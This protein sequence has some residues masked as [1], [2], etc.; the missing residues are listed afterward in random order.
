MRCAAVT[1]FASE[2][3][4]FEHM[5]RDV[6]GS[7]RQQL[8]AVSKQARVAHSLVKN[9]TQ[10]SCVCVQRDECKGKIPQV[11]TQLGELDLALAQLQELAAAVSEAL[12]I[13]T[14]VKELE[15][16]VSKVARVRADAV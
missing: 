1:Q 6:E 15:A 5:R 4:E 7:L 9:G 11:E 2:W 16:L 8:A 12:A 14:R 13:A 10:S 3:A